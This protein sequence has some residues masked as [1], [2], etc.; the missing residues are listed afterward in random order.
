VAIRPADAPGT[1]TTSSLNVD[2]GDIL[3]NAVTVALPTAGLDAGAIELTFDA[4]GTPGPSTD[5]LVD[6][7]G[8]YTATTAPAPHP[9]DQP[10]Y[11]DPP[12]PKARPDPK[13]PQGPAGAPG[14][15]GATGPAGALIRTQ[16]STAVD[17]VGPFGLDT[18]ITIGADGLPLISYYD[19]I[20]DDLKIARC[21]TPT[22][23]AVTATAVDTIGNVGLDTSITLGADGIPLVSYLDATTAT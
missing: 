12:D 7:V 11:Q 15:P 22:C 10:D 23:T 21:T 13:G 2:A 19:D 3:P 6:I 14:T 9:K 4:Y 1:P 18:S 17:S 16:T 5:I 20:N 8:Y